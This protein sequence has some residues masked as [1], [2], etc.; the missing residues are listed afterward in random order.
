M[1]RARDIAT[2]GGLVLLNTTTIGSAVSSVAINNVFSATY[3]A[4][5]VVISGGS[6]SVSG[7][8]LYLRLGASVTG[9][10]YTFIYTSYGSGTVSAAGNSNQTYSDYVGMADPNGLAA[11]FTLVNPFLAKWTI[12]N[13][14]NPRSDLGGHTTGIHKVAT[15]YTDLTI[16]TSGGTMTGGTIKVYGY[17]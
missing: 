3:E 6:N 8:N 7:N 14:T 15:S 1:T 10:A 17:K 12:I 4:Y 5:R 2:Q 11:D 16:L 9:Y 13:A